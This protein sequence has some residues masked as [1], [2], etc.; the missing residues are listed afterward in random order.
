MITRAYEFEIFEEE[1][2][3][4]AVPYDLAG[5]TQGENFDDLCVMV[6]DWLK[7]NLEDFA[8]RGVEPPKP[9]YGNKPRYGGKNMLVCVSAG[10]ETIPKMS[11]A[12]AAEHLGISQSRVSQLVSGHLL[13]GWKDGRNLWITVDSVSAR[14]EKQPHAGRPKKEDAGKKAISA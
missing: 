8:M 9:T 5:A 7:V 4:I 6:S 10:L 13:D 11:A 2:F 12:E 14:L 3:L 1:G